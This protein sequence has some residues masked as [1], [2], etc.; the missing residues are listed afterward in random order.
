M[1]SS[2]GSLGNRDHTPLSH[3]LSSSLPGSHEQT[4]RTTDS[5]LAGH[6][7]L[8]EGKLLPPLHTGSDYPNTGVAHVPHIPMASREREG[9][10]EGE[11]TDG[12]MSDTEPLQRSSDNVFIDHTPDE[13]RRL[14]YHGSNTHPHSPGQ[15]FPSHF[16][17]FADTPPIARR[18]SKLNPLTS[19]T[20]GGITRMRSQSDVVLG[21]EQLSLLQARRGGI[22]GPFAGRS[23]S[24]FVS[25]RRQPLG[26][27]VGGSP[28]TLSRKSRA[29]SGMYYGS[30]EYTIV[31]WSIL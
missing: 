6:N 22:T 24:A 7:P 23:H 30:L 25:G 11:L 18:Q 10:R 15:Q 21:R 16:G 9:Q 8:S 31:H 28:S 13:T 17:Y 26:P 3:K 5:D 27:I 4:T 1:L 29:T 12:S 19:Q 20:N 2:S 14:Q